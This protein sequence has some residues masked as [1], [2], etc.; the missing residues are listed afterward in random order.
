[1]SWKAKITSSKEVGWRLVFHGS[2]PL[3]GGLFPL[4]LS[5]ANVGGPNWLG[6]REVWPVSKRNSATARKKRKNIP[7]MRAFEGHRVH[8]GY[9]VLSLYPKRGGMKNQLKQY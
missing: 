6:G 3:G 1:M 9:A 5:S 4:M 2:N 8:N 7:Y